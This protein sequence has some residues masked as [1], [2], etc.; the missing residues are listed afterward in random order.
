MGVRASKLTKV[1][2][3][4]K[5]KSFKGSSTTILTPKGYIPV[6]VGVNMNESKRFMVHAKSL[7]DQDFVEFLCKSAEEYGFYND[8]ILTI[9]Y[10][11]EAFEEWICVQGAKHNVLRVN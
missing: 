4:S 7:A 8:W 11:A 3:V 9:P 2:G 10:E 5:L 1:I 6:S